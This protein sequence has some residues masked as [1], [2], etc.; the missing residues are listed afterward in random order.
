M[1][2]IGRIAALYLPKCV[3]I[4]VPFALLFSVL[5]TLGGL[6]ASNEV[7]GVLC[8]G[9]SLRRLTL[10]LLMSG[11]VFSAVLFI[12]EDSVV[13]H[14]IRMKNNLY[15]AS[16]GV[17]ASLDDQ[18][19]VVVTPDRKMIYYA[20]FYDDD[21]AELDDVT[22]VELYAGASLLE[23]IDAERGYWDDGRLVL[24]SVRR[25]TWS[26][27]ALVESR[28]DR[29]E[30]GRE[31]T[32]SYESFR[33]TDRDVSDLPYGDAM[34]LVEDIRRTGREHR[35]VLTDTYGKIAFASSPLLLTGIGI[36]LGVLIRKNVVLTSLLLAVAL[37]IVFSVVTTTGAVLAKN[38]YL[39][40]AVGAFGGDL[41]FF[42][43][44]AFLF[45]KART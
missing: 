9:V 44:G 42:I 28:F 45:V 18:N 24:E 22:I 31:A 43:A 30:L 4:S 33:A 21:K 13:V 40:P 11:V 3:T 2:V 8:A 14:T 35:S 20:N 26:H 39:P 15:R 10:P 16:V 27:G 6:H 19:V 17:G 25:F 7:I 34:K 29:Y 37:A 23:R 36:G 38:G 1:D 12:V 32:P 41:L 5:Y